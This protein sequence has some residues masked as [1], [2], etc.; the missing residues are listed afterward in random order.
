MEPR[1]LGERGGQFPFPE[2]PPGPDVPELRLRPG[3]ADEARAIG[4]EGES[5]IV[6]EIPFR[7]VGNAEQPAGEAVSKTPTSQS[8]LSAAIRRPSAEMTTFSIR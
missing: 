2:E 6:G 5:R 8:L 3:R 4:V 1:G 7:G